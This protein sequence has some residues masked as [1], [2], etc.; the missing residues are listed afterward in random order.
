MNVTW[1]EISDNRHAII[2]V[3]S[4]SFTYADVEDYVSS[5][6]TLTFDSSMSRRCFDTTIVND[7]RYE[8]REDFFVNLTTSDL[9]IDLRP[10]NT[11]VMIDDEDSML[12][13][14]IPINTI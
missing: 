12:L 3:I 13:K 2:Y 1:N 5:P 14:K 4:I 8:L 10:S 6:V 11:I 9:D 7:Y